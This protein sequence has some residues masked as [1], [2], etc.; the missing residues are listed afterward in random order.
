MATPARHDL[1]VRRDRDY[2]EVFIFKDG[3]GVVI[4]LTGYAVR[5]QIRPQKDST[6]LIITFTT[7][8]TEVE[9]KVVISLTDAQT[10]TLTAYDKGWWDLVL[11]DPSG[12]RKTY[13]EG[14]VYIKGTVTR[15]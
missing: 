14:S 8:L 2:S 11:T 13:I 7:V 12:N 6:T 1:T 15:A 10:L 5:A 9:G 4:N 3:D